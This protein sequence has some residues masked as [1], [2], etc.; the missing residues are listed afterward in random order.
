M[1]AGERLFALVLRGSLSLLK[2][3]FP[4]LQV[5]QQR[6]HVALSHRK[7]FLGA[8]KHVLRQAQPSRDAQSVRS[9][10]DT[11]DEA[12]RGGQHIFVELK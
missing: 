9:A 6:G 12:I 1:Q 8:L 2:L 10:R 5:C 3:H 4:A 11:L 7:P